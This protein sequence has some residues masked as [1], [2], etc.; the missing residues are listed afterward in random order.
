MRVSV[1]DNVGEL[2]AVAVPEDV[3]NGVNVGLVVC[4]ALSAGCK[5]LGV[6]WLIMPEVCPLSAALLIACAAAT[7]SELST[8]HPETAVA[9]RTA[10]SS[11]RRVTIMRK[12]FRVRAFDFIA[13]FKGERGAYRSHPGRSKRLIR[14]YCRTQHLKRQDNMPIL[15]HHLS[16][17]LNQT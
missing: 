3:G 9:T 16:Y 14:L 15:T 4:V 17:D 2:V 5:A 13:F 7:G 1:G 10:R 12:E 8:A 11:H 6:S